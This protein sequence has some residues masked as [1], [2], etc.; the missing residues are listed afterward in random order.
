M[1]NRI[2][3]RQR[4]EL[5]AV[6]MSNGLTSVFIAVLSLAA[7]SLAK[8]D[9]QRELAVW[10][11]GHDQGVFGIGMVGFDIA[12]LPWHSSADRDFLL[13]AVRAAKAKT[14]WERMDYVPREDWVFDRLDHF[15]ELILAFDLSHASRDAESSW[16]D[17]RP[18]SFEACSKHDVYLHSGGCVVCN[19][20]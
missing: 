13:A 4:P 2:T 11:A 3:Y 6:Q 17:A 5:E 18:A 7:S 1:A 9:R 12:D 8:S 14:G 20:R 15:R 10:L 19:D 16:N